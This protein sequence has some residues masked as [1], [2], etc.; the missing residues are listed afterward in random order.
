DVER[1]T[2][3]ARWLSAQKPTRVPRHIGYAFASL[4]ALE[5]ATATGDALL[6]RLVAL[7]IQ[8]DRPSWWSHD[9]G[10]RVEYLLRE[11]GLV[12]R[13][14][15]QPSKCPAAHDARG[16]CAP[17]KTEVWETRAAAWGRCWARIDQPDEPVALFGVRDAAADP[18][19]MMG[20]GAPR[21]RR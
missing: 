19:R 18:P 21:A 1:A 11:D 12:I 2:V 9:H 6:K 13:Q 8:C 7:A 14:R 16:I 5:L 10:E 4:R 15:T 3:Y 20:R 17:L